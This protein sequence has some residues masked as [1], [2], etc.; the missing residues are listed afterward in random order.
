MYTV[1]GLWT[2]VREKL[3]VT[4]V[5]LSNRKYQILIGEYF[6]VGANPGPTAMNMLGN[7]DI[8]WI[9]RLRALE[10][11]LPKPT[12]LRSMPIS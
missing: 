9:N 6:S 3:P 4:T 7:P 2:Q 1:Q 11:K 8:S 10:W 12:R 5:I